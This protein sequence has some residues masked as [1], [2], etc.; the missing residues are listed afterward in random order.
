[1]IDA[2]QA[3]SSTAEIVD[4]E[5]N[6]ATGQIPLDC[7]GYRVR[8]NDSRF[9]VHKAVVDGREVLELAGLQ[10]PEDYCLELLVRGKKRRWIALDAQVDLTLPGT[11]RFI[12][13]ASCDVEI[14]LNENELIVA[15]PLTTGLAIKES[16]TKAGLIELDFVLSLELPEGKFRI[17]G[18]ADKLRLSP[19]D[20]FSAVA[21]DDNS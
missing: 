7:S 18:D 2:N 6:A 3:E 14:K 21:P 8:V 11:E 5:R 1:M 10:P 19:G 15:G 17:V 16:A 4:L 9:V 20:C 13:E 12:A